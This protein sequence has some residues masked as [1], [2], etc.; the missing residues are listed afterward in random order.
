[1]DELVTII[2][3]VGFPIVACCAMAWFI[4]NTFKDFQTTITET[5]SL[6]AQVSAKLDSDNR[7]IKTL[8]DKEKPVDGSE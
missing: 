3:S 5:N 6:L 8:M 7:V 1:M 2:S 4:N